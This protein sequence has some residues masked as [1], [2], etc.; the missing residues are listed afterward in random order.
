MRVVDHG[1]VTFLGPIYLVP[2][3]YLTYNPYILTLIYLP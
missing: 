2:F 1:Q 3:V